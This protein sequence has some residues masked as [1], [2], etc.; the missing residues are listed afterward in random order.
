MVVGN[1]DRV[2]LVLAEFRRRLVAKAALGALPKSVLAEKL[3]PG[4]GRDNNPNDQHEKDLD[5]TR[6]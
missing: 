4:S 1:L 2:G 3:W 6:Q 5:S